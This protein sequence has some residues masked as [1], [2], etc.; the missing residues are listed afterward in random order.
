MFE[1]ERGLGRID[2][3]RVGVVLLVLILEKSALT[4]TG[5]QI[6][7]RRRRV[8]CDGVKTSWLVVARDHSSMVVRRTRQLIQD[9]PRDVIG[10]S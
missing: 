6:P 3:I 4:W 1:L 8:D 9:Y 5:V 7:M 2:T 10:S